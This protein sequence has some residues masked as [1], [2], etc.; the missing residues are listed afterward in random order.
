MEG[1]QLPRRVLPAFAALGVVAF[2]WFATVQT[3]EGG[4]TLDDAS[5]AGMVAFFAGAACPLGWAPMDAA[6]GRVIVGVTSGD[7]AGRTVGIPLGDREDR[8]HTHDFRTT[9]T[10]GPRN[11]AGAD[12]TNNQGAQSGE[13]TVRGSTA[14]APSGN[15][16]IQYRVCVKR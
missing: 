5:P 1:K 6:A 13:Y 11:I 15:A 3:A 10:L 8:T 16:F 2:G 9:V 7:A 4:D 14:P 12:G